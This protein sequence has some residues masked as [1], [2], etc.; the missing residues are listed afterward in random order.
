MT[1]TILSSSDP[2]HEG[3]TQQPSDPSS[4]VA[5]NSPKLRHIKFLHRC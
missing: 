4:K 2:S 5:S 3:F 1:A